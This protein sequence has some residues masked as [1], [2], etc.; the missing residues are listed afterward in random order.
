MGGYV[1]GLPVWAIA[2]VLFLFF[3]AVMLAARA[4]AARRC[5]EESAEKLSDESVRLLT[6]LAATFAFFV[7][8]AITVTWGA[9][10]AGQA[11]VEREAGAVR[12]MNWAINNIPD[13]DEGVQLR[14]KLATFTEAAAYQDKDDLARG[15]IASLPS[16]IP[17]DRFQDALHTY[18][19][20]PTT[21]GPE[22]SSLVTAARTLGTESAAVSAVAQR[23]LPT[24][25][26]V[27]LMVSGFILAVVMGI[28]T[29]NARHPALMLVWSIVPALSITAVFALSSPFEKAVGVSLAPMQTVSQQ[30]NAR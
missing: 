21:P 17:L 13:R 27:L 23:S 28:S 1:A 10:S 12:N 4:I 6:G 24:M 11:A 18:A 26:V 7:G 19:F 22:V 5:S 30:L 25:V 14:E 15:D 8:F 3:A 2:A 20:R 29:V 9:V 16:A